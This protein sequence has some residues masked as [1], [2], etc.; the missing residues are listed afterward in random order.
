MSPF[1]RI[2]L[3]SGTALFLEACG[4]YLVFNIVGVAVQQPLAML[5]F[6]VV[7]LGAIWA[8]LLSLYVQT[9][10]FTSNLRG[11]LGLAASLVSVLILAHLATGMGIIPIGAF[12]NAGVGVALRQVL[13]FAFLVLL[14]WRC[15]SLAHDEVSLDSVRGSFQWGLV[16]LFLAVIIDSMSDS[17]VISG[18]MIIGFFGV[19]LIGLSL[20]RFSSEA[21]EGQIMGMNW[22][23]PIC[24]CVGAVL[25]AGLLVSAAGLGGL[26][27]VTRWLLKVVGEIG[28]WVLKPVLLALGY[29]AGLLVALGTWI[30][31]RFGGGDL[32]GL[33]RAQE[34]IRQ[35]HETMREE[36]GEGGL[37]PLLVLTLKL[38]GF[39]VAASFA[40]W[41]L[42]KLFRFRRLFRVPGE[43]EETRE[44]VFSWSKV[45]EDLAAIA[46]GLLGNL[47]AMG[48]RRVPRGP[49][50]RNPREFYHA[51]LGLAARR[52]RS[53]EEW[54][55]PRE[56]EG[57]LEGALPE[58]PVSR[59]VDD[60][61]VT[62]YGASPVS[63][64]ELVQLRQVWADVNE[65]VE[66]QER[67]EN[68]ANQRPGPE[69][70]PE[71][72]G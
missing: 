36:A 42:Y 43:V 51:L 63:D 32:S 19:G 33:A 16:A 11:A 4:F 14:W 8:Y 44:S 25:A 71:Q 39:L 35:F 23:L 65:Y 37:P 21:G 70:S 68:D 31:D 69:A 12:V 20:A 38:V 41:L 48:R 66:E 47:M 2:S 17:D 34:Q 22:W 6:W 24:V 7:W 52:G 49:T 13:V 58:G 9:V 3:V 28:F 18:F 29:I 62:Y 59:I 50:P 30:S 1:L 26:D 56:H 45:N 57:T 67:R 5:P 53:R 61:Q 10:R 72:P 40:S 55:T 60:F 15:G 27:D 46:N 54:Q 64:E